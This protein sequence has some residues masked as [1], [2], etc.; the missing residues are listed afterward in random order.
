MAR[1]ASD[2]KL[3]GVV[4]R[5]AVELQWQCALCPN[6][7]WLGLGFW[8][9]GFLGFTWELVNLAPK[10]E[11]PTSCIGSH[12]SLPS[13]DNLSLAAFALRKP[14]PLISNSRIIASI[15]LLSSMI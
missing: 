6:L 4:T 14:R 2:M 15:A 11:T 9:L 10:R 12:H 5:R 8:T 3:V 7:L 1:A 13:P